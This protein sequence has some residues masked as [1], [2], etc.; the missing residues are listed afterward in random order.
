MGPK[1][2]A[3]LAKEREG[4][5][6]EYMGARVEEELIWQPT[7]PGEVEELCAGLEARKAAGW[8]GVAPRV[9]VGCGGVWWWLVQ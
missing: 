1:L 6:L 7:T 2:A 9:V 3:R 8:D 4:A 5:F